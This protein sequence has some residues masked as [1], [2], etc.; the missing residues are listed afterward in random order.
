MIK[1]GQHMKDE[2]LKA[3]LGDVT[4]FNSP[5][6][7]DQFLVACGID[8]EGVLPGFIDHLERRITR[9]T[10]SERVAHLRTALGIIK[11]QSTDIPAGTAEQGFEPLSSF[12]TNQSVRKLS[13]DRSPIETIVRKCRDLIYEYSES[14][15][16]V[17]PLDPFALADSIKNIKLVPLEIVPDARTRTVAGT[18]IL[19]FNPN[20]PR[21]RVRYSVCHEIVHTF[22]PDC[23]EKTRNRA[24][25]EEMEVDDWQLEML[26]NIGAGEL[27]M[28]FD[29]LP[30]GI[31][32][33]VPTVEDVLDIRRTFH[34]STEAVFL[35]LSRVSRQSFCVFSASRKEPSQTY[36]IDYMRP[37]HRWKRRLS[38]GSI[39]PPSSVVK[40]CTA[41]GYSDHRVEKWPGRI[42]EV[43]V[44]CVGIS[45]YQG[46]QTPRVMGIISSPEPHVIAASPIRY[47]R[48]DATEPR[49]DGH[50]IITHIVNDKTANWGGPFA[51]ALKRRWPDAQSAFTEWATSP[52]LNL[53]LGAL[54]FA[55]LAEDLSVATIVCQR[56]Y[57]DSV[58]LRLRYGA[59]QEGLEKLA[60]K[61]SQMAASIHMPRI[62]TGEARGD[63]NIISGLI[64]EILCSTGADVT[65]YTLPNA[66]VREDP[67]GSLDFSK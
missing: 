24:T 56:G 54:H 18:H 28:P 55:P 62:G 66:E 34:V 29:K 42:G 21:S 57:G 33:C 30:P 53:R 26:C 37:S 3:L 15:G 6:E 5:S 17:S 13:G 20:R 1:K 41:I 12:W 44:E 48:G 35:R 40:N 43:R 49:S 50:R 52:P 46:R 60:G 67:Q 14:G 59:L 39:L 36:S 8:P 7:V 10:D 11:S 25:H 58:K 63:W 9:T 16:K 51:R 23:G 19:E 64:E 2:V 4:D 31:H 38:A 27:L 32:E 61:A 65:V 47:V 22:F 45:P